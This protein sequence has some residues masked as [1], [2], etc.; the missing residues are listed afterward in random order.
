MGATNPN[1]GGA[2][3][4]GGKGGMGMNRGPGGNAQNNP[5]GMP[6][7]PGYGG[8]LPPG[9]SSTFGSIGS[10]GG[11]PPGAMPG[12][13]PATWQTP[14]QGPQQTIQDLVR[15]EQGFGGQHG[16]PP[17]ASTW[18]SRNP[19]GRPDWASTQGLTPMG[20]FGQNPQ[21]Y[22]PSTGWVDGQPAQFA[23]QRTAM[24]NPAPSPQQGILDIRNRMLYGR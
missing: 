12:P 24:N 2:P 9:F 14:P 23:A 10:A 7:R 19:A 6:A 20:Q 15:M 17:T 4:G 1:A 3:G 8:Q 13:G 22:Q 5:G 11:Y 16:T 21:P 18:G